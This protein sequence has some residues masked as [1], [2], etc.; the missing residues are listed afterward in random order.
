[1]C[2]RLC[3]FQSAV[4]LMRI[5]VYSDLA[6]CKIIKIL[7]GYQINLI[8]HVGSFSPAYRGHTA[9]INTNPFYHWTDLPWL[10]R[11]ALGR[12]PQLQLKLTV[13]LG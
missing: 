10:Y 11:S 4:F 1:M 5:N 9:I 13:K 7:T 3:M 2:V 6:F 8:N 12:L